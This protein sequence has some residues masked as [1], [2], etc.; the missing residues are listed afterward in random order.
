M[1]LQQTN[2]PRT[3]FD[4]F[5]LLSKIL[6]LL[7]RSYFDS[8]FDQASDSNMMCARVCGNWQKVARRCANWFVELKTEEEARRFLAALVSNKAFAELNPGWP[9]FNS[10]R[11]LILGEVSGLFQS[12]I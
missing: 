9:R 6:S 2:L 10:T 11:S 3:P 4:I 1:D 7:P 5:E 8:D 12:F